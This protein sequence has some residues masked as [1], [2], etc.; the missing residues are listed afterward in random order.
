MLSTVMTSCLGDGPNEYSE[1]REQN[2]AYTAK[3]NTT[4]YELIVPDWA[5]NNSVY[6]KWHNDR[7]LTADSLVAMS[8]STVDIKYELED[9]EG[10]AIE[11]S[12]S[13]ADSVYQSKPNANIIGMWIA[14]TTMHV[15]DS[16]TVIIPYS[17][18]YGSVSNNSIKPYSNLIFHMKIKAIKAYERPLN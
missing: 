18:A 4:E 14:M 1:W 11:N 8:N 7:S 15:G 12:Y 9:I 5:P 6:I 3:I 13:L 2:D 16:A 10:R 17:S